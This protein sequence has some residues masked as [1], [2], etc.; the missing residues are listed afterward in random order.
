MTSKCYQKDVDASNYA[1][2]Y[3]ATTSRAV[4]VLDPTTDTF[5]N[6][7]NRIQTFNDDPDGNPWIDGST[8]SPIIKIKNASPLKAPWGRYYWCDFLCG[9]HNNSSRILDPGNVNNRARELQLTA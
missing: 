4:Y 5:E 3:C 9:Q 8:A 1:M 6:A 2:W 7:L